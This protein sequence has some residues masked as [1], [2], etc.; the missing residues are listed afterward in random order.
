MPKKSKYAKMATIISVYNNQ[1]LV[2]RCDAR[3]HEAKTMDCHC[4]CGGAFHGVGSKIAAEDRFTLSVQDIV[5]DIPGMSR[6]FYAPQE[7]NL[8]G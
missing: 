3:C 7:K 2:G 1:G 8:F 6:V 5:N 4:I